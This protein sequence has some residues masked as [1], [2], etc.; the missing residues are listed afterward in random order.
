M[1]VSLHVMILSIVLHILAGDRRSDMLHL[2]L[3]QGASCG[4]LSGRH[5]ALPAYETRYTLFKYAFHSIV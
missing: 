4:E 3:G 1:N 5:V 2:R